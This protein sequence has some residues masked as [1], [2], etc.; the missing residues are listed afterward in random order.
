MITMRE[1]TM[2]DVFAG[3]YFNQMGARAHFCDNLPLGDCI[4]DGTRTFVLSSTAW[5]DQVKTHVRFLM[6]I[7]T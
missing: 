2:R 4:I 7:L 3:Y 5:N 6:G 1:R